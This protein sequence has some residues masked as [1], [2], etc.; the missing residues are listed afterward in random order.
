MTKRLLW[1]LLIVSLSFNLAVI[2][3]IC[4]LGYRACPPPKPESPRPERVMLPPHLREAPWDPQLRHMRS[5][6]D[7][8]KVELMRELAKDPID[9]ET[10]D[11][12][13]QRSLEL[14][15]SLESRLGDRLVDLRRQM[16][17]EEADRYFS[18]SADN[19]Q[20][21]IQRFKDIRNRRKN[22]EENNR[23]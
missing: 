9:E 22:H 17:A 1:I 8:T 6:F 18:D 14:Q 7:S 10:V 5:N 16:T 19:M 23:N 21:R 15:A 13:L 11:G 20:R 2:I 4:H 12:I 3:S